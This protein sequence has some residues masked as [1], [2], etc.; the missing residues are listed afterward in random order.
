MEEN[1]TDDTGNKEIQN[2]MK[3]PENLL[4]PSSP[5]KFNFQRYSTVSS[6]MFLSLKDGKSHSPISR[7]EI[8]NKIKKKLRGS[9]ISSSL[10]SKDERIKGLKGKF[11]AE[12][13][14][15]SDSSSTSSNCDEYENLLRITFKSDFLYQIGKVCSKSGFMLEKALKY[16]NDFLLIINFYK[17]DMETKSYH[18]LRAHACYYIGIA[19]F[20]LGDKE[21]AE[22][23]LR[24]IQVDLIESEGKDSKKVQKIDSILS[25]YFTER[26][27]SI[28]SCIT[29]YF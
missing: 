27:N 3:K 22:K 18:K 29:D 4:Y 5:S 2:L 9:S 26:F 13:E 15:F 16:L 8:L 6:G 14:K 17:Q 11:A 23:F 20:Q 25:K 1:G 10:G 28:T 21:S 7:E 19:F 24:E 12:E